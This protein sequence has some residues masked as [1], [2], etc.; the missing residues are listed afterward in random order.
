MKKEKTNPVS[1]AQI[2]GYF[3]TGDID[4]VS[5]KITAEALK[6][7]YTQLQ[8]RQIY[9]IL[10]E[11]KKRI[12]EIVASTMDKK[13]ILGTFVIYN[14]IDLY[15]LILFGISSGYYSSFSFN[16][17]IRESFEKK[18]IRHIKKLKLKDVKLCFEGCNKACKVNKKS[19]DLMATIL[20]QEFKE[21]GI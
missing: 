1:L 10:P 11:S 7:V 15:H 13:G 20:C 3:I 21:N 9:L 8:E 5:D 19:R 16:Y 2:Q 4:S 18:N 17:L 12:G 14:N 6:D